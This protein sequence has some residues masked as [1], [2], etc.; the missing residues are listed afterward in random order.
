MI[1]V[2]GI[3]GLLDKGM[4]PETVTRF[5][6]AYAKGV[7]GGTIVIGRDTRSSGR[8]LSMA[9]VSSL[10]FM[11]FDVID[12]GIAST[13]TTEIMVDDLEADGGIIITASHNGPEWNALKFL[14]SNGEFISAEEVNRIRKLVESD[15]NL[16]DEAPEFGKVSLEEGAD[17][18]HVAKILGLDLLDSQ[19]IQSK[20][21]KAVVDC[22]NGA[23]SGIIPLLLREFGVDV[24]ELY[25]DMNAPFPH[26]PEPRPENLSDL[27]E[28]V[29]ENGADIGF[30]CD[31]DADRLVLVDEN[32][33][34]CSEEL[35]LSLAADHVLKSERGP[36]VANLSTTRLLDDIAGKYSVP[37]YRS[38]VGEANVTS[39]MKETGAVIGGEGN[40]GVIYP[41][42]HYGRDAMTGIAV[43][44]QLLAEDGIT[45]GQK[46]AS[47]PEY[48]I[49]KEKFSYQGDFS[50][51]A[52]NV[53]KSFNGKINDI[54]GIRI[55]MDRSWVHIRK[56]N[57][58][59]VIRVIAEASSLQS[60]R[61]LVS[62]AGNILDEIKRK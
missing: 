6:A 56:S 26:V 11:G 42:I 45:L 34:V 1:S 8:S 51:L 50:E 52:E 61:E 60:A 39:L 62:R 37:I 32:G 21:F 47:L 41:P 2:S 23:G 35:T 30:A 9:V 31:P 20:R 36:I 14:D 17:I 55:D 18:K 10:V 19:R 16:F 44:L 49:V 25:T 27:S 3:R 38:S 40:G 48:H 7:G 5:T 43:I 53:K 46:V 57:T 58:E 29:I 24:V 54:D 15:R 33:K 22:V 59:P 13:P 4:N 12:L 28:S